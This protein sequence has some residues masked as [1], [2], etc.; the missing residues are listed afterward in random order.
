M[1]IAQLNDNSWESVNQLNFLINKSVWLYRKKSHHCYDIKQ[2]DFYV[3]AFS[4][5]TEQYESIPTE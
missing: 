4:F 1:I 3:N 2:I 5:T